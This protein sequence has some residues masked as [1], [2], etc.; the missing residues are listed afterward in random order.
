VSVLVRHPTLGAYF[1]AHLL[2]QKCPEHQQCLPEQGGLGS[3]LRCDR[4]CCAAMCLVRQLRAAVLHIGC[5]YLGFRG[6]PLFCK[7]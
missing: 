7:T 5:F 4:A 6:P 3:L 2:L 1:D